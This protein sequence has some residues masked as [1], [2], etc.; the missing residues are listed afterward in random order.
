MAALGAVASVI[1]AIGGVVSGIA[2]NNQAKYEAA[3]QEAQGREEYASSQ[4][5]AE[6][7]RKEAELVNSRAQALSAYSGAGASDPT[8][9]QLMTQTTQQGEYNAQTALYGGEQRKRG[10]FDQAKGTRLT[11]EA[12]LF[13]SFL[14]AAGT[15]AS[16]F[17][18]Y[19]SDVARTTYG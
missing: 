15:L 18:K 19:N 2:A 11:G 12:S 3:Q 13:G 17:G 4:R 9:I 5:D 14:G 6:Q 10:L 16:G 7:K 8:I 1:S